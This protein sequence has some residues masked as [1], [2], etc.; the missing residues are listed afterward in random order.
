MSVQ[1]T[2]ATINDQTMQ[3][4]PTVLG[5]VLAV[6]SAVG[7]TVPGTTKSQIVVNAVLAGAQIAGESSN[8]TV[9]S[10]AQLTTLF[11]SILNATGLFKK[12]AA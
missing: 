8:I 9:A 1:T 5:T 6:E 2:A 3:W 7:S 12:K 4:A 10:I 11:V